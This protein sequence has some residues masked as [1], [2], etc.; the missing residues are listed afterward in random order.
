MYRID[1]T[2]EIDQIDGTYEIDQIDGT[3]E[4]GQIGHLHIRLYR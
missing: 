1:G 4:T 2:D 3:D